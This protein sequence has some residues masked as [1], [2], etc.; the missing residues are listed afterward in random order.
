M[1]ICVIIMIIVLNIG[2][3]AD[4]KKSTEIKSTDTKADSTSIINS[5]LDTATELFNK[6]IPKMKLI[7]TEKVGPV[8]KKMLNDD[9]SLRHTFNTVYQFMPL[10]IRLSLTQKEFT[11]LCIKNKNLLL[12]VVPDN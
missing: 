4:D 8:T 12:E 5:V 10:P 11:D 1:K 2:L 3:F 7:I 9:K 6:M